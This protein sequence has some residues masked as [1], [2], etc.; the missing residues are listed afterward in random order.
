MHAL[1]L[2]RSLG[3]RGNLSELG[4]P[5]IPGIIE[6][7]AYITSITNTN[8][9]RTHTRRDRQNGTAKRR[10]SSSLLEHQ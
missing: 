3:I 9:V 10:K 8:P 7:L 4:V 5:N 6:T 2:A 1:G